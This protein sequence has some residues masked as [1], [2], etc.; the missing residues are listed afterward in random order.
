MSME[1]TYIVD[2]SE[3]SMP[4]LDDEL[5]KRMD[6]KYPQE[7]E[8]VFGVQ[9][10]PADIGIGRGVI[11]RAEILSALTNLMAAFKQDLDLNPLRYVF[12][13]EIIPGV[14]VKGD[15]EVLG[16]KLP[17][18]EKHYC[19]FGGIG[20]CV[21]REHVNFRGAGLFPIYKEYMDM[22]DQTVIE[23][24]SNGPIIIRTSKRRSPIAG[25]LRRLHRFLSSQTG[26]TV[27]KF[28]R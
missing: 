26:E 14:P 27:V 18:K 22:R 3:F 15:D 23:T 19:L 1:M 11:S 28:F 17:G 16:I 13:Y 5:F 10:D 20:Q 4:I 25:D 7:T 2:K 9:Q 21:L 24:E 12:D 8:I 6:Q